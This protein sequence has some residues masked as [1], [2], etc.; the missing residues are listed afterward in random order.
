[1]ET[2]PLEKKIKNLIL[3]VKKNIEKNLTIKSLSKKYYVSAGHLQRYFKL[4]T[5]ETIHNFIKRIRFESAKN[6]LMNNPYRSI[7]DI[8]YEC[9]F[10][11]LSSF[12]RAF[13]E[14]FGISP[15]DFRINYK[16]R[17]FIEIKY[18][19][20]KNFSPYDYKGFHIVF[21]IVKKA[22][23]ILFANVYA[24]ILKYDFKKWEKIELPLNI[25]SCRTLQV[26]DNG[27]IYFGS[28]NDFGILKH[29][30]GQ[31]I[32]QSLKEHLG[33]VNINF[34]N[35]FSIEV[36]NNKVYFQAYHYIFVYE[37]NSIKILCEDKINRFKKLNLIKN[38]IFFLKGN[39]GLFEINNT[40]VQ[41][42]EGSH[43]IEKKKLNVYSILPYKDK[44]LLI[45]VDKGLFIFG[46]N[47]LENFKCEANEL[48]KESDAFSGLKLK[49]D[50]FVIGTRKKGLVVINFE[51]KIKSILNK[52]KGLVNN[53]INDIYEDN[54]NLIWL[55][56]NNGISTF[57][58]QS[59]FHI[60]PEGSGII[61]NIN[62]VIR[63]QGKLY[64]MSTGGLFYETSYNMGDEK[65][66]KAFSGIKLFCNSGIIFHNQMICSVFN[67]VL[68]IENHKIISE[69]K[70][71]GNVLK[72]IKI[73]ETLIVGIGVGGVFNLIQKENEKW[74]LLKSIILENSGEY[75]LR[76]YLNNC[77]WGVGKN[78]IVQISFSKDR[79]NYFVNTY[80]IPEDI[81]LCGCKIFY[82]KKNIYLIS[83]QGIYLFNQKD[84]SFHFV[85]LFPEIKAV[86]I[87]F[88]REGVD[89]DVWLI[90]GFE[91]IVYRYREKGTTY[92]LDQKNLFNTLNIPIKQIDIENNGKV[93]FGGVD[94]L[95]GYDSLLENE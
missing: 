62:K 58:L 87:F 27:N 37:K 86:P 47:K 34:G 53:C 39:I 82:L 16:E 69:I 83:K 73:N 60:Y 38:Q 84:G 43:I 89:N 48:L 40:G 45:S 57:N 8:A 6:L 55:A 81:Q 52:E 10:V 22:N 68:V 5:G 64:V 32:Y 44:L 70:L 20:I 35:I 23:F 66:F 9:G 19:L 31:Y 56:H 2:F 14:N 63:Y 4:Q 95:I 85:D 28:L 90:I 11:N 7:C 13:K 26:D 18:P 24:G 29:E 41:F 92:M 42:I 88:V 17:H 50:Y 30:G 54:S 61:G 1:M 72:L 49:R 33:D 93:W 46:N 67:K 77:L 25:G 79:K 15:K 80:F 74:I 3:F 65:T 94:V 36:Y 21:K 51:G 12:S 59:P 75:N 78:T 71:N 76:F 91:Q